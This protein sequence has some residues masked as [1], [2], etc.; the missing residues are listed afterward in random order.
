M[1]VLHPSTVL[2]ALQTGRYRCFALHIE[3][4]TGPEFLDSRFFLVTQNSCLCSRISGIGIL[5]PTA[6]YF[7]R[8][9]EIQDLLYFHAPRKSYKVPGKFLQKLRPRGAAKQY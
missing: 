7:L 2:C 1:G 3:F 9:P 6:W 5:G 4:V 8:G